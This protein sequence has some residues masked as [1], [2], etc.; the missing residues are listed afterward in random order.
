VP[1]IF[2]RVPPAQ[3]QRRY[4]GYYCARGRAGFFIPTVGGTQKSAILRGIGT[5]RSAS[6]FQPMTNPAAGQALADKFGSQAIVNS[7]IDARQ[8]WL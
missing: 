2:P 5:T 7:A 8:T 3:D 4:P 6:A 1:V